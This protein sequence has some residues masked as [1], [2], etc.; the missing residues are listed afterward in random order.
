MDRMFKKADLVHVHQSE[1][2]GPLLDHFRQRPYSQGGY[3]NYMYKGKLY[4]GYVKDD[5][6]YILLDEPFEYPK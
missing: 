5:Y 2:A 3:D 6:V 1:R 4:H